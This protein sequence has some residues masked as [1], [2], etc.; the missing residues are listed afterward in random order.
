M[1]RG[2]AETIQM[3]SLEDGRAKMGEATATNEKD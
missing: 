1:G 2:I 3:V